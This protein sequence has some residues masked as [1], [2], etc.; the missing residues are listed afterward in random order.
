[1]SRRHAITLPSTFA[2][3]ASSCCCVTS[4]EARVG[5]H[6]AASRRRR[7]KRYFFIP[8]LLCS[9]IGI[10][11]SS[12][13]QLTLALEANHFAADHHQRRVAESLERLE[14]V[15]VDDL[16]VGELAFLQRA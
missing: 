15:G 13:S 4:A 10:C 16:Q 3:A 8:A 9:D 2:S 5:I 14:R 7:E 12:L 6:S 11:S 1:M